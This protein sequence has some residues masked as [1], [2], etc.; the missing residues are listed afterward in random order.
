LSVI[1]HQKG[2]NA[3]RFSAL[4]LAVLSTRCRYLC[5]EHADPQDPPIRSSRRYLGGL[6]SGLGLW[7][8]RYRLEAALHRTAADQVIAVAGHI[9]DKL[10]AHHGYDPSRICVVPNG[11]DPGRFRFS[12][13]ARAAARAR[14]GVSEDA[15]V[16]GTVSRLV[17]VKR[18]DRL[19][20]AVATVARSAGPNAV[21]LVVVGDGP[22][23]GENRAMADRLGI[24]K[25][26]VWA[27]ATDSPW[28]QY[29][30]MDVFVLAS[31]LEGLPLTL[32]EAMA[33]ERVVVATA[34]G[35][36]DEVIDDG[37]SGYLV[38]RDAGSL[39]RALHGVLVLSDA[40]RAALGAAARRR[41]L[42]RH[43]AS[44]QVGELIKIIEQG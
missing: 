30:G 3:D 14:W 10:V 9:R 16:V 21:R 35:G 5:V 4:D 43:D 17:A 32:L 26:V 33:E 34:S 2:A 25:A 42:E 22:L 24:G 44:T 36:P 11:V 15:F 27:G 28:E 1:L 38:A 8:R 13:R 41:V 7:H 29:S 20:E 39:A 12:V 6:V 40:E 18:F 31:D 37:R 19:L 23:E